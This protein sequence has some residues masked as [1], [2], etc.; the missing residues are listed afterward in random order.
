MFHCFKFLITL[1]LISVLYFTTFITMY[2]YIL[3]C[4]TFMSVRFTMSRF[5][6]ITTFWILI[7]YRSILFSILVFYSLQIYHSLNAFPPPDRT[8]KCL[9]KFIVLYTNN[10]SNGAKPFWIDSNYVDNL[11]TTELITVIS[12]LCI[13]WHYR[14]KFIKIYGFINF[15][16]LLIHVANAY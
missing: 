14:E 7:F 5:K 2:T 9:I 16:C 12:L 8:C 1:T 13:L 10:G 3:R 4:S 11:R 6:A 15:I